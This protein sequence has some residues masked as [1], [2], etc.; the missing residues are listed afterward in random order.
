[1]DWLLTMLADDGIIAGTK[2]AIE[3][4]KGKTKEDFTILDEAP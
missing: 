1:M 2:D 3:T 4:I